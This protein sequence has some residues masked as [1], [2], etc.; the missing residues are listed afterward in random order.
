MTERRFPE[1]IETDLGAIVRRAYEYWLSLRPAPDLLPGR[2]HV[3]PVD[4]PGLLPNIW[5]IDIEGPPRIYR[6]R[7]VGTAI[8]AAM[9]GDCTGKTLQELM[10][11]KPLADTL[12]RMDRIVETGQPDRR[13]G[14]PLVKVEN[15][16]DRIERIY[17]PLAR[18]GEVID[19]MLGC[20]Q[21]EPSNLSE[22]R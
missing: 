17:L 12:E 19:M 13:V 22:L 20:A 11:G 10:E 6:Y 16:F 4:I 5:L 8:A 18:N 9:R 15:R 1:T 3:D 2:Q 7:L 21:Y 14:P